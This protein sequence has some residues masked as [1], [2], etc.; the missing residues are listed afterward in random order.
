MSPETFSEAQVLEE[1]K[2]DRDNVDED[3]RLH[4]LDSHFL[5]EWEDDGDIQ[6][7]EPQASS[8]YDENVRFP[9]AFHGGDDEEENWSEHPP[10]L[11]PC[12]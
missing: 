1:L 2:I 12:A 7:F 8:E 9:Y 11:A 5:R 3:R 6:G 4:V 10:L